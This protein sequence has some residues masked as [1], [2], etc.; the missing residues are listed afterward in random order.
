MGA[1]VA[2]SNAIRVQKV[3]LHL[4]C[5][6]K[7]AK[8]AHFLEAYKDLG[9]HAIITSASSHRSL[10]VLVNRLGEVVLPS[11]SSASRSRHL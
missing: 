10:A 11:A 9:R 1:A 4:F 6:V 5:L 8:E 3:L 7:R 2:K